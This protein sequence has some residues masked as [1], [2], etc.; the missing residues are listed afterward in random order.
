NADVQIASDIDL[1]GLG[2]G[3]TG[4]GAE[5]NPTNN[6]LPVKFQ[7]DLAQNVFLNSIVNEVGTFVSPTT[8][9]AQVNGAVTTGNMVSFDG[10]PG[11]DQTS[12]HTRF[13][14][15]V[16]GTTIIIAG[17]EYTGTL[18][19]TVAG[20]EAT[21]ELASG[22]FTGSDELANDAMATLPNVAGERTVTGIQIDGNLEVQ[23][24]TTQVDST[25]VTLSDLFIQLATPDGS[26]ALAGRDSGFLNVISRNAGN[27]LNLQGIRYHVASNSWQIS[28]NNSGVTVN[29][30]GI[31]SNLADWSSIQSVSSGI[32]KFVAN[33]STSASATAPTVSSVLVNGATLAAAGNSAAALVGSDAGT[34]DKY[35]N[36]RLDSTATVPAA[37]GGYSVAT[38]FGHTDVTVQVYEGTEMI[39]TDDVRIGQIRL[40]TGALSTQAGGISITLPRTATLGT[41]KVV[42]IG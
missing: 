19:S 26:G 6:D 41:L 8:T 28:T 22:S 35:L 34:N 29:A 3:A 42:I 20:S 39:I 30:Q 21:F 14:A 18:T 25:T 31:P 40:A 15:G 12:F 36:I 33:F 17:T 23:G 2:G 13:S 1:S 16:A 38:A 37:N 32:N 4:G 5:T 24:D 27:D 7:N 9:T 10:I 11:G